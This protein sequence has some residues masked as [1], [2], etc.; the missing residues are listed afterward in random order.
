MLIHL[1]RAI[2]VPKFSESSNDS[3]IAEFRAL[4]PAMR[5]ESLACPLIALPFFELPQIRDSVSAIGES[6]FPVLDEVPLVSVEI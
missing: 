4:D 1:N 3:L 5:A 2:F 6:L